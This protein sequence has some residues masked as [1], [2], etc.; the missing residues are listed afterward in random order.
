M[1]IYNTKQEGP[2]LRRVFPLSGLRS[3]GGQ[4]PAAGQYDTSPAGMV[5]CAVPKTN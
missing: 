3:G 1:D 5:S 4:D 2:P